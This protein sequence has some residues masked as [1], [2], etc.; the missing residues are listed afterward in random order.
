[1]PLL[2]ALSSI[3]RGGTADRAPKVVLDEDL[4]DLDVEVA[5]IACTARGGGVSHPGI[6]L[7][8]QLLVH[9]RHVKHRSTVVTTNKPLR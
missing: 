6:R 7:V 8:L 9:Q 5:R 2:P 3:R 4:D 1:V